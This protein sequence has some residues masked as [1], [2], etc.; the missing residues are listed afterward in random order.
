VYVCFTNQ[1]RYSLP[2]QQRCCASCDNGD[3]EY[4][5]FRVLIAVTVVDE[6][7]DSM[8]VWIRHSKGVL[9]LTRLAALSLRS[10]QRL[11]QKALL[12]THVTDGT[13]TD[14]DHQA[15]VQGLEC[16]MRELCAEGE[17]EGGKFVSGLV[18]R[19]DERTKD[20]DEWKRAFE[21]ERW[22]FAQQ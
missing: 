7:G 20:E 8:E 18:K 9:F 2:S 10:N 4:L 17:Q 1:Q 5:D 6:A 3:G 16:K 14:L 21:L 12:G 11:Q 15:V 13:S 19:V 22:D